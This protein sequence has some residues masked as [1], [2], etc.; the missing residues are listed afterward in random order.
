[1]SDARDKDIKSLVA[2]LRRLA[3]YQQAHGEACCGYCTWADQRALP[4]CMDDNDWAVFADAGQLCQ[5][6]Q[7]KETQDAA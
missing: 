5:F 7:A 1:M 6:W 2:S 4:A 3:N